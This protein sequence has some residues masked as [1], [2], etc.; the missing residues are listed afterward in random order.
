MRK[1]V[2][3]VLI[4]ASAVCG[5]A[6]GATGWDE[7]VATAQR[8][9][10]VVVIGP[11]DSEVRTAL[12]A[13]F[14]KRFG[15]TIDYVGGRTNDQIPKLRAERAAGLYTT[16]VV[17]SGLQTAATVFYPEK[18]LAP[19]KPVLMLPEVVDGTK[20]K[21]GSPW[22]VDPEQQYIL[23]ISNLVQPSFYINTDKVDLS[24]F[25]SG[26]D[27]LDPKWRGKIAVED[28]TVFGSGATLATRLFLAFGES[29][30]KTLYVDQKPAISRDKRQL[31]DWLLRGTYPIVLNA[32]ED[33]VE[34]MRSEGMPILV[35]YGLPDLSATLSAQYGMLSLFDQA[36]HPAAA[37]V[38]VN[39]LASKEG[40]EIW[41]RARR[42]VPTRNDI[43]ERDFLPDSKIPQPGVEYLD[44]YGWEFTVTT[45]EKARL[46]AKDIL[47][48]GGSN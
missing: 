6:Y 3:A 13:A 18:M 8:E 16:D 9:G 41:D 37:T 2:L 32:D 31:T 10:K 12:P 14:K 17:I 28:P 39:W 40:M 35:V 29:G 38:F 34:K 36:P 45:V 4:C 25:K 11:P 26:R 1:L 7:V 22:F 47:G 20:W 23:R 33:Q 46:L 43:D 19:L 21:R 44:T 15:I 5:G 42:E 27:L 48:R 24:A 30:L